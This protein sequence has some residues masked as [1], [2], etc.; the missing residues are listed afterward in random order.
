MTLPRT[1]LGS[2][3]IKPNTDGLSRSVSIRT[4]DGGTAQV[5]LRLSGMRRP[6]IEPQQPPAAQYAR[7]QNGANHL[8]AVSGPPP[9]LK[10]DSLNA[11]LVLSAAALPFPLSAPARMALPRGSTALTGLGNLLRSS[12]PA[13]AITAGVLAFP[14][15]A[16]HAS[17]PMNE[18]QRNPNP[19]PYLPLPE[20]QATALGGYLPIDFDSSLPAGRTPPPK[21]PVTQE[22]P[23]TDTDLAPLE[24]AVPVKA[25]ALGGKAA[26][27]PQSF[28]DSVLRLNEPPKD[29]LEELFTPLWDEYTERHKI[30]NQIPAGVDFVPRENVRPGSG[31]VTP[32]DRLPTY[33]LIN[34]GREIERLHVPQWLRHHRELV[35]LPDNSFA[36]YDER[37]E[38][39]VPTPDGRYIFGSVPN[40]TQAFHL[41]DPSGYL[42]S[43]NFDDPAFENHTNDQRRMVFPRLTSPS[44]PQLMGWLWIENGRIVHRDVRAG[45]VFLNNRTETNGLVRYAN[46]Y[47]GDVHSNWTPLDDGQL[48]E[49]VQVG[50]MQ[51]KLRPIQHPGDQGRSKALENPQRFR[52]AAAPTDDGRLIL[53]DMNHLHITKGMPA[54]YALEIR[55]DLMSNRY[56]GWANSSGHYLSQPRD[57]GL[58]NL[59]KF[60]LAEDTLDTRYGPMRWGWYMP[61]IPAR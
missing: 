56:Q 37:A 34:N 48:W 55:F 31:R 39:L 25:P 2:P 18:A 12:G 44:Q 19:L 21:L 11:M 7:Q 61:A 49:L 36:L 3:R 38:G 29:G 4:A 30:M 6:N 13:L 40:H 46:V 15:K 43:F 10:Q 9:S 41:A 54:P 5:N 16:G 14:K 47:P 22:L 60:S 59:P 8:S 20:Q 24:G 28:A 26:L 57:V 50:E 53:S 33:P 17:L 35:R 42:Y 52:Y 32:L 51:Y 58:V 23:I 45:T 1:H 27:A